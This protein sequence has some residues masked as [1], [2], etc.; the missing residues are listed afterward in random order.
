VPVTGPYRTLR[1]GQR[2]ADH[3]VPIRAIRLAAVVLPPC[4]FVCVLV[5]QV[6]AN[7]MMLADFCPAQPREI[8]LGLIY[9]RSVLSL[10]LDRVIDP[11]LD[12]VID[13]VSLIGRVQAFPSIRGVIATSAAELTAGSGENAKPK[14]AS[15]T[16]SLSDPLSAPAIGSSGHSGACAAPQRTAARRFRWWRQPPP[17]WG[18]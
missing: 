16:A 4:C 7:P 15:R 3:R 14:A 11:I 17:A 2:S 5:E 1:V 13:P 18:Q 6:T 10:I 12:R 8:R 9:V